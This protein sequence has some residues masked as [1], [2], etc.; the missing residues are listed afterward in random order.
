[1]EIRRHFSSER[2]VR[3]WNWLPGEVIESLL[4]RVF[5]ERLDMML[6]DMV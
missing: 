3:H 4:L 5:K 6:R 1:M 2:S